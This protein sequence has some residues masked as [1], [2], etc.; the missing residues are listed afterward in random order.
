MTHGTFELG[1]LLFTVRMYGTHYRVVVRGH[2]QPAQRPFLG[3]LVMAPEEYREFVDAA[4][5][6]ENHACNPQEAS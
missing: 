4:I 5:A 2:G 3:E 1:G 6:L